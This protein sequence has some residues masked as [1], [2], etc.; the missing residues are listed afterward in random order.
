[1]RTGQLDAREIG[2]SSGNINDGTSNFT[3]RPLSFEILG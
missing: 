3:I 1:M 2:R